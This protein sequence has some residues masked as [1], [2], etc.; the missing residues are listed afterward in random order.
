MKT[1]IASPD[2]PAAIGPYSQ[3]VRAG[4]TLY[5]S[6]QIGMIPATGA[7]VSDCVKEQTRQALNNIEAV[8]RQAG[9]TP[10]NVVKSTVFI[11][12]MAD[13]QA[14]NGVYSEVFG[15]EPPARSC[16]AVKELPK[17]AKVEIETIAVG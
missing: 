4:Q 1:I 3:A 11:T 13:F 14:V 15:Q 9:L 8:L 5:L 2:A 10:A 17:G 6:G 12:D 16:V 7:L